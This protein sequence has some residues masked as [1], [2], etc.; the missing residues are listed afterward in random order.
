MSR[1]GFV[2]GGAA[3]AGA[4][5]AGCTVETAATPAA[6][7]PAATTPA[8]TTPDGRPRATTR[9][10]PLA[11]V[12]ARYGIAPINYGPLP[13]GR[14]EVPA[15]PMSLIPETHHRQVVPYGGPHRPGT[16]VVDN[17]A[18]HLFLI[19]PAGHALRYGVGVGREGLAFRGTGS[20]YR[21]A[22]WP[23]WTPTANMIRRDP[24]LRRFAGGYPGGLTNPLGARAL[25]L[26]SGGRDRGF[27][28]HGTPEWY[29]IGRYASS[30]CIRMIQH[31]VIDLYQRVPVGT[32]VVVV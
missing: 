30:G 13:D 22:H 10:A 6:T 12:A 19:L 15:Q 28:I 25:Y 8:A 31:D 29:S 24:S 21:K 26:M 23:T 1:R 7:T 5:L 27:R 18:R 20:I 2:A 16:I 14:F 11:P 9:A 4:A 3:A 32:R 17:R